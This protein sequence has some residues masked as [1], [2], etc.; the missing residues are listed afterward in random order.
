MKNRVTLAG[1]FPLAWCTALLLVFASGPP[2]W[3]QDD[4]LPGDVNRDGVID[5]LDIQASVN[6]ALGVAD[7]NAA[8][9]VDE[10][11]SVD[12]LDVQNIT[13]TVL[14]TGGLLQRVSGTVVLPQGA[15]AVG[16]ITAIAISDDGRI[17]QRDADGATGGFEF[18]LPVKT[19]WSLAFFVGSEDNK[20]TAGALLFPLGEAL[21]VSLP[22]P[23][24]SRGN[25]LDLGELPL[26]AVAQAGSDVRALLSETAEPLG[27]E[28][29]N[30]NGAPD[31]LEDWILP[32][33]I[34]EV[35]VTLGLNIDDED[36]IE[37][38]AAL[39]SCAE[40]RGLVEYSPD[41]STFVNGLPRQIEPLLLCIPFEL[42]DWVRD[43]LDIQPWMEPLLSQLVASLTN[44]IK[45]EIEDWFSDPG[46]PELQDDNNNAVPDFIETSLCVVGTDIPGLE[47]SGECLLDENGD[48]LPD[49][50]QDPGG[51]GVPQLFNPNP[52]EG[53]RDGDGI[54]DGSDVDSDNNGIPDY[55]E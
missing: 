3:A 29:Y 54:P 39:A 5:I 12:V 40:E 21:S 41:L 1:R 15:P 30:G 9:D 55:A 14:G 42:E 46:I 8:A 43:N 33:P 37:I 28:D 18:S 16:P 47:S 32:L 48:G 10:N 23:N 22:L 2:G 36:A 24:L 19:S 50:T 11:T 4:A 51:A 45:K 26:F 25:T 7:G 20:S 44:E 49:F 6:M 13:N 17:V 35:A 53:D 52:P 31:L 38:L 34:P 27:F